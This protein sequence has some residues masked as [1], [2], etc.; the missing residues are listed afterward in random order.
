M[1]RDR[2][3]QSPLFQLLSYIRSY[4]TGPATRKADSDRSTDLSTITAETETRPTE[5]ADRQKYD[6]DLFV[7]WDALGDGRAVGVFESEDL[8]RQILAINPYYYRYYRCKPGQ[9]TKTALEWLD[10]KQRCDLLKLLNQARTLNKRDSK[11]PEADGI[12][13]TAEPTDFDRL[14]EL[15]L[16]ASLEAHN[17]ISSDFWQQNAEKMRHKYLPASENW[18]YCENDR[19]LGFF[20]LFN[21]NLSALFVD[22]SAQSRGIGRKLL[23]HAK[24]LRPCLSLNVYEQNIRAVS[25]YS[26]NGFRVVQAQKDPHTGHSELL[27]QFSA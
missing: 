24:I 19:I 17:F 10:E 12:I 14:T 15:W 6:R 26:R 2:K 20:S 21:D 27:M 13:R 3:H 16:E 22:P 23:D 9:A 7:V 11:Q 4:F 18:V 5:T 25:F 1:K 8:V